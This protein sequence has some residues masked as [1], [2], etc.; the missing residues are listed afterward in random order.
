[1]YFFSRVFG[2]STKV[3]NWDIDVLEEDVKWFMQY[4]VW[5]DNGIVIINQD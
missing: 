3:V 5:R 4:N 2:G 1:M